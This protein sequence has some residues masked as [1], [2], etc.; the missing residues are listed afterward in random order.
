MDGIFGRFWEPTEPRST[1]KGIEKRC[2]KEEQRDQRKS[3][4]KNPQRLAEPR[5]LNPSPRE[6]GKGMTPV[7]RPKPP[8]PR[9]LVGFAQNPLWRLTSSENIWISISFSMFLMKNQF[10][11]TYLDFLEMFAFP[12]VFQAFSRPSAKKSQSPKLWRPFP[13]SPPKSRN[14]LFYKLQVEHHSFTGSWHRFSSRR[15]KV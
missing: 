6:E 15:P 13:P 12:Q 7:Q 3:L 2:K 9:G 4:N 11:Q 1:Q 5:V 10:L 8:Q 14:P